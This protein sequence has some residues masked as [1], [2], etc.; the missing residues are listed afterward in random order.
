MPVCRNCGSRITKFNKDICPICGCK[1]PLEGVSSET[2][3][4]TQKVELGDT[5]FKDYKPCLRVVVFVLFILVGFSGAGYFYLKHKKL[6]LIWLFANLAF[7][8]GI[9]ALFAFA[10]K[11]GGIGFAVSASIC[12]LVNIGIGLYYLFKNDIKDGNGDFIH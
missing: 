4:V 9:G 3:E 5:S 6:G 10:I 8:G 11:M 2:I 7:I 12:Y 1:N